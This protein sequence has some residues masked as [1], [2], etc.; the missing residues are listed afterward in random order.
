MALPS[1]ERTRGIRT[2]PEREEAHMAMT[3]TEHVLARG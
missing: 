3:G 1:F 2:R